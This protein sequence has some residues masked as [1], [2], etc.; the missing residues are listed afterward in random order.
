[1]EQISISKQKKKVYKKVHVNK[2]AMNK[3]NLAGQ[4][5]IK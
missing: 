3:N 4:F 5:K 1:M 2:Y